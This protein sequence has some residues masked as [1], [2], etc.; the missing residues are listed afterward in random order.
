MLEAHLAFGFLQEKKAGTE[1][2]EMG[3][4][5]ASIQGGIL[6]VDDLPV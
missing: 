3:I 4:A 2:T 6:E 5:W 1:R